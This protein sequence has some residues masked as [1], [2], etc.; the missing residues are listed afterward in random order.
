MNAAVASPDLA[1]EQARFNMIEQQIRPW[2]VL[3]QSVLDLLSVVRR[4]EFVPPEL[5]ALAFVDMELPL[6]VDGLDTGE[7]MFAP[8]MEARFLQELGIKAH[9]H[10]LEVGTGSGYMAALLAHK[11]QHVLTVEIDE[12]LM[13][14]GRA[15]LARAGV[16][17]V[18]VE[19]GDGA[20]GWAARAPYDVIMVSGS[21]P[22]LPEGL[23]SQLKIGGRLAVVLGTGPVMSAQVI[24][25]VSE[26]GFDTLR[27]FETEVK[28]L[29]NAWQ[30]SAFQ[31]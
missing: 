7:K 28:P 13:R 10:V 17:S 16:G 6:R 23:Q 24:T 27:L 26:R 18:R 30:P 12:R 1:L 5:R 11:A 29:R 20:C 21:L 9:E 2:D 8:K 3:D 15:N 19:L 14:F 22:A 25:R 4:E 31:F